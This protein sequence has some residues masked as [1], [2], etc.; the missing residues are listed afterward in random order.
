MKT[1]IFGGTFNPIHFGHLYMS[2]ELRIQMGYDRVIFVPSNIPAHKS[3]EE[4]IS[5]SH[6][7]N[8]LKLALKASS[9]IL[10]L[11]EID[12]GGVSYTID[13]VKY[14]KDKYDITGPV[15][16]F[17]GDDLVEG[18]NSWYRSDELIK[19]VDL[20]IAHRFSDYRLDTGFNYRYMD[21]ISVK[22]S[23]SSLRERIR[24]NKAFRYLIPESIYKYIVNKEIYK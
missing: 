16:L 13:T 10:E 24:Q 20:V 23:S 22:L 12:R 15:G 11:C 9:S 17:I 2:E 3:T 21:N 5:S 4:I 19:Q 14:I 6:R 7:V 1:V 8:M 18:M